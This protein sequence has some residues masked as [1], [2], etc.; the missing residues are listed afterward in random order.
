MFFTS[1]ICQLLRRDKINC[2][3]KLTHIGVFNL[4]SS[5]TVV[6]M[7]IKHFIILCQ[8]L[9]LYFL[10]IICFESRLQ[11]W[12]SKFDS[13]VN[14]CYLFFCFFFLH[15]LCHQFMALFFSV[16]FHVACFSSKF[17]PLNPHC[18]RFFFYLCIKQ[19]YFIDAI[20]AAG[21]GW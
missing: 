3:P 20:E 12:F 5:V 1:H 7:Q 8:F 13:F 16:T 21:W 10:L 4:Q 17:P 2:L 9:Q 6:N 14:T 15:L 18:S 11:G 19:G